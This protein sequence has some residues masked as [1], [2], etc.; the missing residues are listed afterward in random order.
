MT[1]ATTVAETYVVRRGDDLVWIA[2][3]FGTTTR[4]IIDANQIQNRS[5]LYRG[6]RLQIPRNTPANTK[7]PLQAASTPN[8][9]QIDAMATQMDANLVDKKVHVVHRGDSPRSI[10][11]RYAI[12]VNKLVAANNLQGPI[13]FRGQQLIIPLDE[14]EIAP[15]GAEDSL[16]PSTVDTEVITVTKTVTKEI[17]V[18]MTEL[19]TVT[20][21]VTV[22]TPIV[23]HDVITVTE[24]VT[25]TILVTVTGGAAPCFSS[26]RCLG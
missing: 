13:L 18:L 10:A 9:V 19:I 15:R 6:Q 2:A 11:R 3:Q 14:Q 12:P 24:T 17:P 22:E 16:A 20:E 23:T 25:E 5:I 8:P 4:A 26:T 7:L 1:L 21:V